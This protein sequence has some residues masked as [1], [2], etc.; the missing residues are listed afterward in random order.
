MG[1]GLCHPRIVIFIN[2]RLPK[3]GLRRTFGGP[4][5]VRRDVYRGRQVRDGRIQVRLDLG[6]HLR[7]FHLQ[8]V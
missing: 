4:A 1:S 6:I 3:Q 2:D 8:L 5:A 7:R